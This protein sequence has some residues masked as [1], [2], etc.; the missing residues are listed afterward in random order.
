[1]V[2]C[3]VIV[4]FFKKTIMWDCK[5]LRGE[6]RCFLLFRN[7]M[8]NPSPEA[9]SIK[10]AAITWIS[11]ALFCRIDFIQAVCERV[12]QREVCHFTLQKSMASVSHK[13]K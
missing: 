9:M 11:D 7:E 2:S 4:L 8:L 13:L 5:D 10:E 3:S 6:I 12:P 1:M